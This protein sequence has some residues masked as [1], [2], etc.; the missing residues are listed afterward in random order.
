MNPVTSKIEIDADRVARVRVE[1]RGAVQGVGF[2]PFVYQL[3]V[4][5]NLRGW[6]RNGPLGVTLEAEGS[7]ADLDRFL[8]RLGSESPPNA[9]IHGME[10]VFLDAL[11]HADFAILESE[12][13]GSKCAWV[14]PD[15]ATCA[16]CR[17]EIFDPADRRYRY[18]FTNC[19]HCG[20]RFTLIESL[21][22][23][24]RNTTMRRFVM[25][26][27]CQQE[28]EDPAD[29]RFHAQP[30]ACPVCGPSLSWVGSSG[31]GETRG[32][33][34]LD[35]AIQS[36]RGGAIVAVKG[37]GGFHLMTDA[38]NEQAVAR[39]RQRKHR[40]EKP[41]A[42]MAPGMD[43]VRTHC[44]V[45]PLEEK[46]LAAPEAPIVLL[47]KIGDGGV[48]EGIAP[49]R[50][51]CL[52]ILLPHTPLH[53]LLLREL[54]FPL[55]ATSGNVSE[56]TVCTDNA[57]ALK[58]LAP[59]VDGLLLHDR[60]IARHADDSIV[61]LVAGRELVLRRARGFA[62]LPIR[63]E[64][65]VPPLLAVGGHL[66]NT[67]ALSV[68]D[69]VFV[70]QHVGDL[71][72]AETYDAF[73]RTS[74]DLSRLYESAPVGV[75]CDLHPDY[76]STR[77]AREA[78]LPVIGVQHH[79]AHVV[80]CMAENGVRGPALGIAWD[81]T[82]YGPDG[83]LWGGEF[84]R[85]QWGR[86]TWTRCGHFRSFPLP[87]GEK[88]VREPRRAALGFLHALGRDPSAF[89]VALGFSENETRVLLGM[90]KKNINCP[91]TCGVGRL[92]DVAAALTGLREVS[93]FE[94]QA[95]MDLEFTLPE[96]RSTDAAYPVAVEPD[97]TGKG[98][99]VD[100]QPM[101]ENLLADRKRKFPVA[102]IS[103]KFHNGLARAAVEMYRRA[104]ENC[105]VL[106]G[107]CFQNRYLLETTVRELQRAG[108]RVY[109]PQRIPPND[110][111]LALGQCVAASWKED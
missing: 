57:E 31:K 1:I 105:V 25:C 18:P 37:L 69:L 4:G 71:E 87:G 41:F 88:A 63:L 104:E 81:G 79:F 12:S 66:K 97:P 95:A 46:L 40:E 89:A 42:L 68:G 24:R 90:L 17:A 2:R 49:G 61:R 59:M 98:W 101:G 62:P 34:A 39:L 99:I 44:R 78:G 8:L 26:A 48:A 6:V 96:R 20:P 55:V 72:S 110:G 51:P 77:F 19:T 38:R 76:L 28:Y 91:L 53:H 10:P 32:G 103:A 92:F 7:R 107:G 84:L 67:V 11:G 45:S 35:A 27:D 13:G 14:L 93:R 58:K 36:L 82:G 75:A 108:A 22:Y 94:G 23:D 85:V 111:G 21:P 65:P 80:A 60:P 16:E 70:S 54:G 50:N 47:E 3:A 56:E 33:E 109:W 100:W 86:R 64:E 30:N 29:R 15:I 43:W 5:M 73:A 102:E 106:S 9:R 52:G 74:R 83:T